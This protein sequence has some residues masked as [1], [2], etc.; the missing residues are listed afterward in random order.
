MVSRGR[1][2]SGGPKAVEGNWWREGGLDSASVVGPT[3]DGS[4]AAAR[5]KTKRRSSNEKQML[6]GH[7]GG[8]RRGVELERDSMATFEDCRFELNRQW[9]Y[10][11]RDSCSNGMGSSMAS[12]NN[13]L[14]F[15]GCDFAA[16]EVCAAQ[17][18]GFDGAVAFRA[19][20][21]GRRLRGQG[22][23][24]ARRAAGASAAGCAADRGAEWAGSRRARGC[25][26]PSRRTRGRRC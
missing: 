11:G 6:E 2:A 9:T 3:G 22:R 17:R 16:R 25:R 10:C 21:D 7:R 15:V 23:A 5:T 14:T 4:G 24:R 19:V 26:F 18:G 20:M 13:H 1:G 12:V 8:R